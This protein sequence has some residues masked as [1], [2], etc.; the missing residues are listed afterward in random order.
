MSRITKPGFTLFELVISVAL[1]SSIA[2]LMVSAYLVSA[3]VFRQELGRS[4]IFWDGQWALETMTKEIRECQKI[5]SGEAGRLTIWWQDTNGNG[6]VE[7]TETVTYSLEG[8]ALTRTEKGLGRGLAS[9]V[10]T[11]RLGYNSATYPTFVTIN[12][13][14]SSEGQSATFESSV[15]VRNM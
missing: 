14:L 4:D 11:W 9:S 2:I 8:R 12:L 5:T 10:N 6:L 15:K 1:Y 13:N 3:H 7:T